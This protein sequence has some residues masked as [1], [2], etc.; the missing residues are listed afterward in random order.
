MKKIAFECGLPGTLCGGFGDRII[1]IASTLTLSDLTGSKLLIKWEDF[2][3]SNYF[4]YDEFN[5]YN[6]QDGR[7]DHINNHLKYLH[8]IK[9]LSDVFSNVNLEDYLKMENLIFHTNQNIW[10]HFYRNGNYNL[11][12]YGNFTRDLY[13]RIFSIY[14]KPKESILN[15][16]DEIIDSDKYVGI[17][18][19]MGDLL[20]ENDSKLKYPSDYSHY[21]N[22]GIGAVSESI[23]SIQEKYPDYNFFITSDVDI[24]HFADS[25]DLSKIK[26]IEGSPT[27][28][29]ISA[30]LDNIEKTFIDFFCLSKCSKLFVTARSNFGRISTFLADSNESRFFI[31]DGNN[32]KIIDLGTDE[33]ACKEKLEI[34]LSENYPG[35]K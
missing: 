4:E 29:E 15:K 14:L 31:S 26:Y 1:G 35:F 9:V 8:D 7:F 19:R 23:K 28:I 11:G 30:S 13:K 16:V 27:H 24:K 18:I 25:L 5:F 20:M 2:N 3:L 6:Q 12:E 10:Q 21:W 17:Q 22:C 32:V 33:I 34:F